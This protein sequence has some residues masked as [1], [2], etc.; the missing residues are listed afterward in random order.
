MTSRTSG[1]GRNVHAIGRENPV[2]R[3][4]RVRLR[5]ISS[6]L[7]QPAMREYGSGSTSGE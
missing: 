3:I 2:A 6:R 1:V 4:Q 5:I 7:I